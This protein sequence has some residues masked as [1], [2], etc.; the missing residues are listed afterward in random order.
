MSLLEFRCNESKIIFFIITCDFSGCL[1]V[2]V[3]H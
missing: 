1:S 3:L 2:K